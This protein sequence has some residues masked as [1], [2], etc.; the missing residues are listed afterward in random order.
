VRIGGTGEWK[1]D[2]SRR[3]ILDDIVPVGAQSITVDAPD[4]FFSVGDRVIVQ[5]NM[6]ERP[7]RQQVE[8]TPENHKA[9]LVGPAVLLW[10][11]FVRSFCD[12]RPRMSKRQN[13]NVKI[14]NSGSISSTC[15]PPQ[16]VFSHKQ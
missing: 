15:N 4:H 6:T 5:R 11:W 9:G 3:P 10:N 1:E 7:E 13:Q 2:R 12:R 14:W 8:G 16:R